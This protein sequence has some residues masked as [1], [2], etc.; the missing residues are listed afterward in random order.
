MVTEELA[1]NY[2]GETNQTVAST[3]VQRGDH[4]NETLRRRQTWKKV[5]GEDKQNNGLC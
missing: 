3:G 2:L 4:K 1:T 5:C